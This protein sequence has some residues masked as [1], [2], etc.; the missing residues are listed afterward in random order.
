MRA[1]ELKYLGGARHCEV[2]RVRDDGNE[3]VEH[4]DH[5]EEPTRH[6][7]IRDTNGDFNAEG[8]KYIK[9]SELLEAIRCPLHEKHEDEDGEP[10][11]PGGAGLEPGAVEVAHDHHVHAARRVVKIDLIITRYFGFVSGSYLMAD[12]YWE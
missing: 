10:S 4:H 8:T 11:E 3:H 1:S 7:E 2:V 5:H 12:E 9:L 6:D